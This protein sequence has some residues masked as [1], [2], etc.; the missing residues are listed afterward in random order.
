MLALQHLAL[1]EDKFVNDQLEEAA[2]DLLKKY[3]EKS[4]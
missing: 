4:K 1:H 2:K 3:R